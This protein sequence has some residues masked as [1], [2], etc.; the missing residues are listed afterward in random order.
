M[1][2]GLL[3]IPEIPEIGADQQTPVVSRL[4]EIVELQAQA[5]R[6]LQEQVQQQHELIQQLRDE[7]AILKGQKP[8]PTISP[9][10]LEQPADAP[11]LGKKQDRSRWKK[12]SKKAELVIHETLPLRV[13]N[14]PPGSTSHGY[15]EFIVQELIF[16]VHTTRYLRERLDLP[17]GGS[18]LAPLPAAVLPGSHFGS[19]LIAYILHEHYQCRV[20]QGVLLEK[21]Q[22]IGVDISAGQLS[23]ILI[24][25]KESYHQEKVE[26]LVAG[27][28]SEYIQVDDTGA[29]HQG[30]NGY[31]LHIGN[32]L[33]AYFE[34]TDS[35]SR[36]NF[37]QVLR[38]PH[39]DYVINDVTLAYWERQKLPAEVQ[40]KLRQGPQEFAADTAW[41]T[42]LQELGSGSERHVR[43][44]T[45]GA[46]LGSLIAHG[47][48]PNLVVLSDGASQF[49]V[50]LHAACW[51]HVERLLAKLNPYSDK[52]R[53]AI[54]SI[55]QQ[56][57][58]VY[59][60]LKA[61]KQKPAAAQIAILE[62]RFD[63][64]VNQHT[65]FPSIDG[66]L[67]DMR[68]HRVDMLR[69]LQ[70]PKVPLHNNTSEAHLRDYVITRKIRG[71]TRSD[72]GRRCRD[73]FATLKKTC[74]C[75]GV[76][77]W[78]YLVDRVRSL[79]QVPRLADLIRQR[80]AENQAARNVAAAPT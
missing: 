30:K 55:R 76:S 49:D 22:Q 37:L 10:R 61:Y 34:S 23:R 69:I 32:D 52:H 13:P 18:M 50:L 20:T 35:K 8:R 71:G 3:Y 40:D 12:R 57:W 36:L 45:E 65:G 80:Q 73:T 26:I 29:R 9:S 75:L 59:Q 1:G 33:F 70:R 41:Q 28:E 47:V 15:E 4:L 54:E 78:E 11:T 14:P 77:F 17:A 24:E 62:T 21:L 58:E 5:I 16:E 53:A 2:N 68:A 38:G 56:L 63:A 51:I 66:V 39:T 60:E 64:M 6:Q 46:L 74:R 25:N 79:A 43:M 48:S 31:C 44:A 27:R 19:K 67:K 7:I 72:E 42:R